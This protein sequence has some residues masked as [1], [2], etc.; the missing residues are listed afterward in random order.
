V[1]ERFYNVK[2]RYVLIP[3]IAMVAM[4]AVHGLWHVD[5][6]QSG[7]DHRTFMAWADPCIAVGMLSCH[8]AVV[9]IG[10]FVLPAWLMFWV[11]VYWSARWPERMI[12]RLRKHRAKP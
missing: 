7:W 12:R 9:M 8:T 6:M 5:E 2:L 1:I 11:V 3:A 10:E 4:N